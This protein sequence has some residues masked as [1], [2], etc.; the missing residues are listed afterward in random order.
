MSVT[1]PVLFSAPSRSTLSTALAVSSSLIVPALFAWV[2]V[3]P[4]ADGLLIASATLSSASMRS[5]S[6]TRTAKSPLLAPGGTVSCA[7]ASSGT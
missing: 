3:M 1:A 5:S 2:I 6:L 7:P 4:G